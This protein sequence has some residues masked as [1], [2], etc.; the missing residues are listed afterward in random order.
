MSR[1]S[2]ILLAATDLFAE[3]GFNETCTAEIA[4]R[5]GVAQGTLFYHFKSK[6]GVLLEVFTD[7]MTPYLAGLEKALD[8]A[9]SGRITLE[10]M[11][12]FHFRFLGD[13]TQQLLVLIRDFPCH[14]L[15]DD[16]PQRILVREQI[17]RMIALLQ[18]CLARGA[19]D[20]SLQVG[21]PGATALL[22]RGLLSGLTRQQ[23]LSPLDVPDLSE[24]AVAFCLRALDPTG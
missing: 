6:E 3:K 15:R 5:A 24:A 9:E 14:L 13:N 22:L 12:R 17:L 18:D 7:I 2:A 23:L 21:D 1:K 4:A 16:C 11:L 10:K 20:G 19:R 8:A